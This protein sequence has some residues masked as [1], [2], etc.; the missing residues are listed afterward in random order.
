[1]PKSSFRDFHPGFS[2]RER[3]REKH[4][5]KGREREIQKKRE[6]ERE[7]EK[8]ETVDWLF[9]SGRICTYE[10]TTYRG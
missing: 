6:R 1:M 7:R 3:E 10:N 2:V 5:G 8:E 9:K 4:K